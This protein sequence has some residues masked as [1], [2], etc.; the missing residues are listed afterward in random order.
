MGCQ[1]YCRYTAV[2]GDSEYI[3][4][5]LL[6]Q[7]SQ[8]SLFSRKEREHTREIGQY[9]Y[10]EYWPKLRTSLDYYTVLHL[11]CCPQWELK[12]EGPF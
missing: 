4:S 1:P 11:L 12:L 9:V 2:S 5:R 8:I 10:W 6:R 7:M 3:G